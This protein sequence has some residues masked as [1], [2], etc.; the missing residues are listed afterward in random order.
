MKKFA[1]KSLSSLT[2]NLVCLL[3]LKLLS[4]PR[5]STSFIEERLTICFLNC[6]C[7]SQN[8]Y[9]LPSAFPSSS[10]Q[11]LSKENNCIFYK[12]KPRKTKCTMS[13]WNNLI[14][15]IFSVPVPVWLLFLYLSNQWLPSWPIWLVW[16]V[17]WIWRIYWLGNHSKKKIQKKV[18]K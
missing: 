1:I 11:Q 4:E 17:H 7:R 8:I 3:L 18:Q 12:A 14:L 6:S 2:T 9:P 15:S 5:K 13:E 16:H 10:N